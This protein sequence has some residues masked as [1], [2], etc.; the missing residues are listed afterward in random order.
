MLQSEQAVESA[1]QYVIQWPQLAS[2]SRIWYGVPE[3]ERVL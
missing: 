2:H 1:G 3:E